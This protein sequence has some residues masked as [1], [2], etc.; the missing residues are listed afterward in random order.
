MTKAFRFIFIIITA[1]VLFGL[2]KDVSGAGFEDDYLPLC[3]PGQFIDLS[4]DCNP[5]GP[6]AY[7]L[8]MAEVGFTF[9]ESPL[10]VHQ[11]DPALADVEFWYAYVLPERAPIYRT[12]NDAIERNSSAVV[13]RTTYGFTYVSI[14]RTRSSGG[15]SYYTIVSACFLEN[16]YFLQESQNLDWESGV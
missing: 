4:Q 13:Q 15:E 1:I 7:L 9:P 16:I 14:S 6:T 8:E 5:Y 3:L 11:P 2:P 10:P 12:L